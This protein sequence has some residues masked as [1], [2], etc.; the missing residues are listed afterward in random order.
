M[1]MLVCALI[2]FDEHVCAPNRRLRLPRT[3]L[4]RGDPPIA[5]SSS[6]TI[7]AGTHDRPVWTNEHRLGAPRVSGLDD[8]I[9]GGAHA[10]ARRP[11]YLRSMTSSPR[12]RRRP[13]AG[14]ADRHCQVPR[15]STWTAGWTGI[16]SKSDT[17]LPTRCGRPTRQWLARRTRRT[18][19]TARSV[20]RD[21]TCRS[22]C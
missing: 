7:A 11:R 9:A 2:S 8:C 12:E 3:C 22:R 5:M 18:P 16:P 4:R 6:G 15:R 14:A 13:A 20:R 1:F 21:G 19:S 10:S 17:K